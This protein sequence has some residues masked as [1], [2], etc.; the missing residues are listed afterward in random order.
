MAP[1]NSPGA[2][3]VWAAAQDYRDLSG[4]AGRGAS[5][6]QTGKVTHKSCKGMLECITLLKSK[7]NPVIC[8]LLP[9]M[10]QECPKVGPNS[11]LGVN[12]PDGSEGAAMLCHERAV[13]GRSPQ[14]TVISHMLTPCHCPDGRDIASCQQTLRAG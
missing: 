5:E 4:T 11:P 7:V 8:Q 2:A 6:I 3:E 12:P 10:I 9:G 1:P 13:H 14:T